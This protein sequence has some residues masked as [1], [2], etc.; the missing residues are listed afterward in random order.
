MKKKIIIKEQDRARKDF[1]KTPASLD[2]RVVVSLFPGNLK[3]VALDWKAS[4]LGSKLV[5]SG[6][7][8]PW[9]AATT[10]EEGGVRSE[11][12]VMGRSRTS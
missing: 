2:P 6:E 9:T 1:E 12:V 11:G 4:C 7:E 10:S 3:N 8:T 5:P